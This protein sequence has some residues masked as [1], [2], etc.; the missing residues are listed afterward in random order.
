MRTY[1][2]NLVQVI[3]VILIAFFLMARVG[4]AAELYTGPLIDA[5]SHVGESFV[6]E[7]MVRR[8]RD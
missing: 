8:L 1:E 2:G 5:H 4:V 7:T 3:V 6:W